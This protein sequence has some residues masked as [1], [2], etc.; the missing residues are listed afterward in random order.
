MVEETAEARED[1]AAEAASV[2]EPAEAVGE[3]PAATRAEE[4]TPEAP[5]IPANAEGQERAN[6]DATS[7]QAGEAEAEVEPLLVLFDE[8]EEALAARTRADEA[9][10]LLDLSAL[11][12]DVSARRAAAEG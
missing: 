8:A 9:N 2:T 1:Q 10:S 3:T 4:Q 5:A 7:A 12:A 11:Q 6:A